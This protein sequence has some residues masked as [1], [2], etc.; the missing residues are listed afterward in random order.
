MVLAE[1]RVPIIWYEGMICTK[2]LESLP[3]A[4]RSS[5]PKVKPTNKVMTIHIQVQSQLHAY[6]YNNEFKYSQHDRHRIVCEADKRLLMDRYQNNFKTSFTPTQTG[7][8]KGNK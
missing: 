8:G 2:Q 3:R 4:S 1:L 5:L 6:I 7:P